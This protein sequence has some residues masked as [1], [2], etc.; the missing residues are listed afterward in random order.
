MA[1]LDDLLLEAAGRT[2]GSGRSRHP[3]PSS[4]RRRGSAYS[5]D[6]SDSKDED[7]DSHR[8]YGGRKSNGPH[9][10]LKKRGKD[11][12]DDQGSQDDDGE[13]GSGRRGGSGDDSDVGS[14]LY[15]DE[16]DR[17]QL[18]QLTEL[19]R[20][21]I[22]SDRATKLDDKKLHERV[23][24]RWKNDS[25]P[26]PKR[27]STPPLASSRGVRTSARSADRVS[28]KADALNELRAKRMRQQGIDAA[29]GGSGSRG[30]SPVKRKTF[31]SAG[32]SSSSQSDSES[33][34]QS[35]DGRSKR[36]GR[37]DDSDDEMSKPK[38]NVPTYEDIRGVTI[39]RSRLAKWFMEPFFEDLIVGCFVRVGIGMKSG[40]SIY[41]LCIV[42]N[43]DASD[44]DKQYKLENKMTYKYLNCVWGS[45]SSAARWQMARISD[46]PPLE[47]EYNQWK[48][49]VER[50]SG[51][52]PTRHEVAEKKE[53]IEKTNSFVYSAETV[54]HMLQ[55]KKS[56]ATRPL[57]IA[58]EKER[59]R[60]EMEAAQYRNDDAQVMKIKARLEEL[61]AVR[62]AQDN[63]NSKAF[64]LAEMNRKNRVENF[65]NA[66]E[67]KP[68][69]LNLKSGEAGYDPFSRRWTRSTNYYSAGDKNKI[70]D[71]DAAEIADVIKGG[72]KNGVVATAVALEAAADAGKLVDT[73]APVD[74][75]TEHNTLHN[76]DL[77]ISLN[78]LQKFGGP[79]GVLSGFMARKQRIEA[80]IGLQVPE[81]DGRRHA[82][83]LSVSDY[84]RRRGLL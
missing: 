32:L 47:E 62:L 36:A 38:S 11:R 44:P 3:G 71:D 14:D 40:H 27:E 53:E 31:T 9:I 73:L 63:K 41:R 55:E 64:R 20:E 60:R 79:Q 70:I 81:N 15:K 58:A 37:M 39:R 2:G 34:S 56:A 52:M 50:T 17:Q 43:V 59:L 45:E 8:G 7:S 69:N 74:Q 6:G 67:L 29:K 54:K 80:T 12:D 22:L 72:E 21:L 66:S 42:R 82:L 23:K 5:D 84:K 33:D 19:E 78:T 68:M 46:S 24:S 75:G 16:D 18:A 51:R 61:A 26:Q 77:P 30:Y 35:E 13:E 10:P 25:K 76:F 28:N 4:R 83:T 49:E 48:K 1:D 65:K 57:N